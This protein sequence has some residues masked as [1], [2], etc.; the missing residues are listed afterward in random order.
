M[1][2]LALC[3]LVVLAGCN[4]NEKTA[5]D[6]NAA[7]G[8]AQESA[9][10]MAQDASDKMGAMSGDIMNAG[11]DKLA[12]M[13]T[14]ILDRTVGVLS[15]ITNVESAKAA[16]PKLQEVATNIGVM[17]ERLS[18]LGSGGMGGGGLDALSKGSTQALDE[19]VSRLDG[20]PEVKAV[21]SKPLEAIVSFFKG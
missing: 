7:A 21:V 6:A 19:Q 13:K 14:Q 9:M 11:M 1:R 17:K 2:K 12:E 8:A 3:A 18:A 20:M 15:Q 16:L 4:G 10:G 5:D